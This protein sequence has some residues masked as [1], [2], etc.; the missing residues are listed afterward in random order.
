VETFEDLSGVLGVG[1][2]P[3]TPHGGLLLRQLADRVAGAR[4]RLRPTRD[5]ATSAP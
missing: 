5:A 4:D 2:V 3:R 1:I